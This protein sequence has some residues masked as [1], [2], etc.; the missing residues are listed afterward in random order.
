MGLLEA[1]CWIANEGNFA[2]PSKFMDLEISLFDQEYPPSPNLKI[3][4]FID[5]SPK[6]LATSHKSLSSHSLLLTHNNRDWIC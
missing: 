3:S 1:P 6:A 5:S 2:L 4:E